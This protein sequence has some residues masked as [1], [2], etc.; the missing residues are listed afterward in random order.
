MIPAG[1]RNCGQ[2]GR[3]CPSAQNRRKGCGYRPPII[4][5]SSRYLV[6]LFERRLGIFQVGGIEA[7]SEPVV[8]VCQHR[9]AFSATAFAGQ[10]SGEACSGLKLLD[11]CPL[12]PSNIDSCAKE[13]SAAG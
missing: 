3:L 10:Q 11:S 4:C 13:R 6:E 9:A 1:R 7:L 8:D 12:G 5:E 2:L